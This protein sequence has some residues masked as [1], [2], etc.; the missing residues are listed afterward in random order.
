MF[1]NSQIAILCVF[2]FAQGPEAISH[3]HEEADI[4]VLG[5]LNGP[6]ESKGVL[7]HL[8]VFERV[9]G[10]SKEVTVIVN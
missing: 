10:F 9:G 1:C 6:I 5:F 8:S 3:G 2:Q 7:E 4:R